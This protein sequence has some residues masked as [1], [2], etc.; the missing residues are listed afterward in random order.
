MKKLIVRAWTKNRSKNALKLQRVLTIRGQTVELLN[1]KHGT[2]T[3]LTLG[4][5]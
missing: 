4:D 3:F 2:I 1:I 5:I